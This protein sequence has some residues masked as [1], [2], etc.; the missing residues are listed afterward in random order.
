MD[1]RSKNRKYDTQKFIN[2]ANK[3]HN[4]L[5]DYSIMK[6]WSLREEKICKKYITMIS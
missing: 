6:L 3:L 2:K 1:G 4:N 5:Y